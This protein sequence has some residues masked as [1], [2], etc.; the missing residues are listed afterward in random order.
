M[1]FRRPIVSV[2]ILLLQLSVAAQ[3]SPGFFL[4]NDKTIPAAVASTS[5]HVYKLTSQGGRLNRVVITSDAGQLKLAQ[6]Q[7]SGDDSWWQ[8]AQLGYCVA[9]KLNVCPVFDQMGDGSAFTLNTP[10]SMYTNLH[11][12]YE[13][14]SANYSLDED[15][16]S[17]TIL[18][19]NLH[20]PLVFIL[21]DQNGKSVVNT[22]KTTIGTLEFFNPSPLLLGKDITMMDSALGRVS[23]VV[24]VHLVDTSAIPLQA[25]KSTTHI[26]DT[27]YLAGYP[28]ETLDRSKIGV[29]DS[30][31]NSLRFS[32]GKIISFS[33]WKQR[34]GN[35]FGA[36]AESLLQENMIFFDADCEHGNSGGPLLNANGEVVGIMMA[37]YQDKQRGTP[38]R[39]CG[40][41]NT[42][43]ESKL[44]ALWKSLQ[45]Q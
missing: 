17:E 10:D 31:G 15:A 16:T 2:C 21:N 36:Q 40:A 43:D 6:D 30:D 29:P 14:I 32:V 13:V 3:A 1:C 19:R 5:S 18:K 23:D 11:N 4:A 44:A 38:Y 12:F 25:S 9:N 26:G 35:N 41:I 8:N 22:S 27:V 34:T 39:V 37:L 33:D 24:R 42:L 45:P 7:F 20:V 28:S